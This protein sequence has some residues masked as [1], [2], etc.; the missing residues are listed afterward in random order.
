MIRSGDRA[1]PGDASNPPARVASTAPA[2]AQGAEISRGAPPMA[3]ATMPRMNAPTM[4]VR[5]P[6]ATKAG[7]SSAYTATPY[8]IDDGNA[9]SMA[10]KPPQI[11]PAKAERGD[12]LAAVPVGS[13]MVAEDD[14]GGGGSNAADGDG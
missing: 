7:P 13:G 3:E 12:G 10:A 2:G 5:T 6:W 9:T 1:S 4:P 11:S 14:T 8:A